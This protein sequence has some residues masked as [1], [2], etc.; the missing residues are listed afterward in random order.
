MRILNGA[1]ASSAGAVPSGFSTINSSYDIHLFFYRVIYYG[2][3]IRLLLVNV[4][5]A[6]SGFVGSSQDGCLNDITIHAD[7][8]SVERTATAPSPLL[9]YAF[10]Y[11]SW[12]SAIAGR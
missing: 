4:W 11:G 3:A 6:S 8:V 7:A 10:V 2:G 12:L 1:C 9:M 5:L